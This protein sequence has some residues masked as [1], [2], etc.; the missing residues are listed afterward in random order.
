MNEGHSAF[1]QLERLRELVEDQQIARDDA[2]RRLRASTVFTTHTPVPAGNEIFD[3]A[4]VEQNVAELVS[5]CGYS[6]DEFAALGRVE[7][8]ET[9]FGLTPFALRTSSYANGVSALHGEVSRELWHKVWPERRVDDVPI[10][11]ITNGVHARTWLADGLDRLLGSEED[12]GTP[13]FARAYEID[14][15]ALWNMHRDAKLA[16]LRFMGQRGLR[17]SFDPDALTIGFARRFATYKRADLLFSRPER[18]ARS[19]PTPGGRC[20]SSSP[21]RRIPPTR[22]AR[23]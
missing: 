19:S 20:R 7:A 13:D 8:A 2:L 23:S 4:L 15:D 11:S 3:P 10:G 6:W 21:A 5:R 18:L 16:L 22:A 14:D 9:A 17:A 1:L 12:M